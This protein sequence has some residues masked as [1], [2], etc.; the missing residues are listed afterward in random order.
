MG[1]R[2]GNLVVSNKKPSQETH[3][4]DKSYHSCFEYIAG[5]SSGRYQPCTFTFHVDA[6]EWCALAKPRGDVPPALKSTGLSDAA[7]R[8]AWVAFRKGV[9]Q[10]PVILVLW[11]EHVKALPGWQERRYEGYLPVT[12]DVTAYWRPALKNC[13]SQHYHPAAKRALPA[14][15]FGITSPFLRFF[16][17]DFCVIPNKLGYICHKDYLHGF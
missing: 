1:S 4:H 17:R 6:G 15:I 3:Y 12:V 8:R 13:P 7:T 10:M 11:R 9:W 2:R 16:Y 14:V 5:K